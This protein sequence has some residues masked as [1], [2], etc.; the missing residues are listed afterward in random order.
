MFRCE[1]VDLMRYPDA[2]AKA[3]RT[4][5]AVVDAMDG[6]GSS[7]DKT[8]P[9]L[10]PKIACWSMAHGLATQLLEG[11]ISESLGDTRDQKEA[12]AR[13]IIEV[14]SRGFAK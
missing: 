4:F 2:K 7:S 10:A 13:R 14:F 6:S 3:D 1:M 11:K 12:S 8:N 5:D 9:D